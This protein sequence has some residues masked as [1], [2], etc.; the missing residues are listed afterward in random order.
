MFSV[1]TW[2]SFSFQIGTLERRAWQAFT[3]REFHYFFLSFSSSHSPKIRTIQL[4]TFKWTQYSHE[5]Y[6]FHVTLRP[7]HWF[8]S[9]L[10]VRWSLSTLGKIVVNDARLFDIRL[11]HVC[12]Q[13][14][15]HAVSPSRSIIFPCG[16]IAIAPLTSTPPPPAPPTT[17]LKPPPS[18]PVPRLLHHTNWPF[19]LSAKYS[20]A[21]VDKRNKQ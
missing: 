3:Q 14:C 21:Y 1:F 13:P 20:S 19:F 18:S 5:S 15:L 2:L 7:L 4:Y 10:C 12:V 17:P 9:C 8:Q 16:F 11:V 6:Y